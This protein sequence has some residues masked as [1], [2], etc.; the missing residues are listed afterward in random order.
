M[1]KQVLAAAIAVLSLSGAAVAHEAGD[2][3]LRIGVTHAD[4]DIS[5]SKIKWNGVSVSGTGVQEDG[6]S[7]TQLGLGATY[8]IMPHFGLEATATT[9]FTHKLK[10]KWPGVADFSYGKVSRSSPTV[11]AQFFFLNPRSDFQPYV[12]LGVNYSIFHNEKINNEAKE[13]Y[14]ADNLKVK[15][16]VGLVAQLGMDYKITDR[17]FVNASIWK[18]YVSG[19]ASWNEDWGAGVERMKTTVDFDPWVYSLGAGFKF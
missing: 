5:S 6:G 13:R 7:N 18:M 9:P 16:S 14:G 2:I 1:R 12:G 17:V 11:S 15:N 10:S 3:I 19:K 8:M 4:P